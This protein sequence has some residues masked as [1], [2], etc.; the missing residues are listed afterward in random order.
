MFTRDLFPILNTMT[1]YPSIPTFHTLGEKGRFTEEHL[2]IPDG[3]LIAT[4]KIDGTNARIIIDHD[5]DYLIG[6]RENLLYAKGDRIGDP[7]QGI[8]QAL[9]P[10]ADRVAK[11]A[12]APCVLFGEVYGGRTTACKSYGDS[13]GFRLFDVM[14]C[15]NAVLNQAVARGLSAMSEWRD[16]GGQAFAPVSTLVL[17]YGN[18]LDLRIV[19]SA[20]LPPMDADV[21]G[22]HAWFRSRAMVTACATD[23][24]VCGPTEGVVVR[25][26]DRK[27]ICK[28]RRE[29]YER[30]MRARK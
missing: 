3:E 14:E 28:I 2:T 21:A 29:D 12:P 23:P 8:V 11:L 19:P 20:P 6:S 18:G 17:G 1:K 25:S 24:A 10:I 30:T 22:I 26:A 27:F 7:A 13:V 9:V 15:S 4:E 16:N 5:G